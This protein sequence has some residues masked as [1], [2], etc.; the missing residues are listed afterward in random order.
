M[1][2]SIA[3]QEDLGELCDFAAR[4]QS[5]PANYITYLSIDAGEIAEELGEV[6]NWAQCTVIAREGDRLVGWLTAEIDD[7][8]RRVCWLG[9]FCD[10]EGWDKTADAL[11]GTARRDITAQLTQ[12]EAACD[13]RH[14]HLEQWSSR[15]GLIAEPASAAL[16]L[17]SVTAPPTSPVRPLKYAVPGTAHF[18]GSARPGDEAEVTKLHD[19]YFAGTHS[20]GRQLMADDKTMVRV[21]DGTAGIDGYIATQVQIDGT[22]YIDFLAVAESARGQGIGADLIRSVT[23]TPPE[24]PSGDVLF[25]LTVR[26]E[27]LAARNLYRSLGFHESLVLVPYRRGFSLNS[28]ES[29]DQS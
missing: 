13:S 28:E 25:H 4:L 27:N 5:D 16:E 7:E 29:A 14:V 1:K 23:C 9:P 6:P 2:V 21:H 8:I 26:E 11:L 3:S 10:D 20:T 12:E 15:H 22:I 24:A 18:K 17:T 19:L